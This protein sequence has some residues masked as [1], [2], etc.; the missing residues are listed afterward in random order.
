MS[1]EKMR[2]A[3]A[4]IASGEGPIGGRL[5][6]EQMREIARDAIGDED[7]REI[8]DRKGML[9]T[10]PGETI[11][12]PYVHVLPCDFSRTEMVMVAKSREILARPIPAATRSVTKKPTASKSDAKRQRPD[13]KPRKPPAK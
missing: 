6:Y 5:G 12:L 4:L 2:A 13:R 8:A 10:E 11:A 7:R 1:A 3:L 9:F